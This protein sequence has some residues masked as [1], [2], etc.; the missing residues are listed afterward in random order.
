M[1]LRIMGACFVLGGL[2]FAIF[3]PVVRLMGTL[4]V[5]VGVLLLVI[6]QVVAAG[7]AHRNRLLATGKAGRA[8]I[9]AIADT[10]VTVNNSPRARVTVRIDVPGEPP[11][12][13]QRAMMVS[14]VSPPRVGSVYAVRFDPKNPSD[15]VFEDHAASS[16]APAA[17][18]APSGGVGGDELLGELERL[19]ALRNTGALTSDEFEQQKRRLLDKTQ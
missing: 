15:F 9:L 16:Y 1:F 6:A 14:R 18:Y 10:G 13:G 17:S 7:A 12:E 5:G 3:M 8:T 19:A 4:W 2:A 11:L